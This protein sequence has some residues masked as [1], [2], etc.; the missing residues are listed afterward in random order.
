MNNQSGQETKQSMRRFLARDVGL[1]MTVLVLS[2]SPRTIPAVSTAE[3][4]YE[5]AQE[6]LARKKY[7]RAIEGFRKTLFDHAGSDLSDDAQYGLARSYFLSRDYVSAATEYTILVRDYPDSPHSEEA[8][9]ELGMCYLRQSP[10][11]ELDQD[12][13]NKALEVFQV[14]LLKYPESKMRGEVEQAISECTEKLAHKEYE[15]GRL[16]WKLKEMAPA[17]SCFQSVIEDYP[18]TRW[19]G[20]AQY[21]IGEC[22]ELEGKKKEAVEA[23]RKVLSDF[24]GDPVATQAREKVRKLGGSESG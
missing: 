8:Q 4:E 24:G 3:D 16:Y 21:A 22:Y 14:F 23:Y 10:G 5:R 1:M 9:Y 6:A 13:T 7:D 15:N 18:Q 12:M 19:A 2:C 11:I 20:K 17:R